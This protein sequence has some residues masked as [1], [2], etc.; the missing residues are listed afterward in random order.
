[1]SAQIT[2]LNL[3]TAGAITGTEA[4]AIVQGG[5]TV[6]TTTGAISASPSQTQTFLTVNQESTLPN[7]RYVGVT[8]GLSITDGGAQGLYK[9]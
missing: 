6:Q 8:N 5:I 2:I 7:S 4:V 1:M 9:I 3:P